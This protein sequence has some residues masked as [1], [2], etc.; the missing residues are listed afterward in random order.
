MPAAF[1]PP[2]AA[3]AA[4]PVIVG[5]GEIASRHAAALASLGIRPV[6]LYSPTPE[7]AASAARRFGCEVAGDLLSAIGD[8]GG[9]HVHVCSPPVQHE[10]AAVAA[11]ERGLSILCEKPLAPTADQALRMAEAV[12]GRPGTGH[13]LFNRRLDGGVQ[14]LRRAV[15][16]GS[17]GRPVA[18]FGS[19]RQRWN[20]EPS[21]LDWRFDPGQVGPSRV[22]TE[23]GSH[24]LD[25]V[26]FVLDRPLEAVHCLVANMGERSFDTGSKKGRFTP[27][28]EDLFSAQLR[29]GG[30]VVGH[31]YCTELA[32][33]CFDEIELRLDGTART[34]VWR[35]A[36]PNQMT[37]SHKLEGSATYGPPTP[38]RS[39]E[40]AIGA[41]Y[42]GGEA[43]SSVASFE[44]GVV[45]ALAMDA[46][47]ESAASGSWQEVKSYGCRA[48][49]AGGRSRRGPIRSSEAV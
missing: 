25:L 45:V 4:R 39:I 32:H 26:G 19:Y 8:F 13:V 38:S 27:E 30:G 48:A 37:L 44:D 11:A 24:L 7:H 17:V 42:L 12:A 35:S 1:E 43:L 22:V 40:S 10:E 34:A 18:V 9:T 46:M 28:S 31:V 36:T 29:L 49:I 5:S 14:L 20:A 6:A 41:V 23:I 3:D 47:M 16:D 33:D 21:S 2:V 15:L